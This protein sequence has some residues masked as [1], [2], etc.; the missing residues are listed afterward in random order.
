MRASAARPASHPPE[1]TA[2]ARTHAEHNR[3]ETARPKPL[4]RRRS[5]ARGPSERAPSPLGRRP[6]TPVSLRGRA[7]FPHEHRG[8]GGEDKRMGRRRREGSPSRDFPTTNNH[9]RP[10]AR[11]P[12]RP[13]KSRSH[14]PSLSPRD[15]HCRGESRPSSFSPCPRGGGLMFCPQRRPIRGRDARMTTGEPLTAASWSR[16]SLPKDRAGCLPLDGGCLIGEL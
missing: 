16:L 10:L 7:L 6:R 14:H 3:R 2:T 4:A 8:R 9:H 15:M 12:T 13:S 11:L 5:A 1:D